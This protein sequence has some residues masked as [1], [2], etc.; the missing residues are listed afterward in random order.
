MESEVGPVQAAEGSTPRA[1]L[2]WGRLVAAT[3]AMVVLASVAGALGRWQYGAWLAHREAAADTIT[4]AQP[5]PLADL[6][7]PDDP[8][9]GNQ[10]GHPVTVTGE[11]LPAATFFVSER[12]SSAARQTEA[13]DQADADGGETADGRAIRGYWVV[14]PLVIDGASAL[15]VVRGWLADPADAP[16]PPEGAAT[17]TGW[18]QP[19]EGDAPEVDRDP[20]D[21][22]VPSLRVADLINRIDRDSYGAYV[23]AGDR[24][25]WPAASNAGT[26]GLSPAQLSERPQPGRF[27]AIRNIFY[28]A[29]W[30]LF[31]GFVVF[32]WQRYC[33]DE[34][35]ASRRPAQGP[36]A[37]EGQ[38]VG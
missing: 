10:T 3:A 24:P 16:A 6:I 32:V 14:T 15:P 30:W 17:L 36:G 13:A 27:Q 31:A 34:W 7:G 33:R 1:A 9:P 21:D 38:Q 28:A 12:R 5:V 35:R 18:L 2:P 23:V 22:V 8:F 11:W 19:P 37:A 4:T 26:T 29:E 20:T 25:G